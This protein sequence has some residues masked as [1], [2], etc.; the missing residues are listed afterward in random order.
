MKKMKRRKAQFRGTRK[1]YLFAQ[2]QLICLYICIIIKISNGNK[3]DQKIQE[4]QLILND[5][6]FEKVSSKQR[7]QKR[8]RQYEE[9]IWFGRLRWCCHGEVIGV[10]MAV[11]S[12]W[13]FKWAQIRARRME[14][15]GDMI[16]SLWC[17]LCSIRA[18]LFRTPW[19]LYL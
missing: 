18:H 8:K 12:L 6:N 10:V 13:S 16:C 3:A 1:K 15:H 4:T 19:L 11:S 17:I 14:G 5:W 9:V 2:Q 7:Q